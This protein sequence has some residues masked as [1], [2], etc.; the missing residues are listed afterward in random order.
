VRAVAD[1]AK[2]DAVAARTLDDVFD[3]PLGRYVRQAIVVIK[4]ANGTALR[5]EARLSRSVGT[6]AAKHPAVEGHAGHAV[7]GKPLLLGGDEVA[8]GKLGH[9]RIRAGAFER[10]GGKLKQFL[11]VLLHSADSM[12]FGVRTGTS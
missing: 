9:A 11:R 7:G 2:A 12:E 8:R 10:L 6:P 4:Q 1:A 3:R 5:D